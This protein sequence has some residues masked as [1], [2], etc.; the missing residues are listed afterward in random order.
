[1]P[2]PFELL[3]SANPFDFAYGVYWVLSILAALALVTIWIVPRWRSML[4][5]IPGMI[6]FV[7]GL[8]GLG[9]VFILIFFSP[10]YLEVWSP[11]V[12]NA[13]AIGQA[14]V[15]VVG[16]LV[17]IALW[18]K[19]RL[20]DPQPVRRIAGGMAFVGALAGT[21]CLVD[22]S[23]SGIRY[24]PSGL[25]SLCCYPSFSPSRGGATRKRR[26]PTAFGK[27]EARQ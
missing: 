17:A 27:E 25:L 12:A 20:R 1:M 13:V 2:P 8:L 5:T 7:F 21:F 3:R 22:S 24:R 16:A 26:A 10:L 18:L 14:T 6:L 23:R 4:E 19:H 9:K 15:L 11:T